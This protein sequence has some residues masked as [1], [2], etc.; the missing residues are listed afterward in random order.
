LQD[1]EELHSE[2]N[3]IVVINNRLQGLRSWLE[4]I[5]NQLES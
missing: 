4:N 2:E 5:V 3:K 1:F